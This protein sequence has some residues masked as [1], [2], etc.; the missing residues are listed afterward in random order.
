[1]HCKES[2]QT[3]SFEVRILSQDCGF[4]S[5]PV[6]DSVSLTGELHSTLLVGTILMSA[7]FVFFS[8]INSNWPLSDTNLQYRW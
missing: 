3:C 8:A 5:D 6:T 1:M 7:Y 4:T 2:D